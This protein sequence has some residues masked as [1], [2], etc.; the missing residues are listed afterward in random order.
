MQLDK[1]KQLKHND[2]QKAHKKART[3][4]EISQIKPLL[5]IVKRENWKDWKRSLHIWLAC[6]IIKT[7]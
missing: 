2:A 5:F 4:V 6:D 3:K 7:R 1:S